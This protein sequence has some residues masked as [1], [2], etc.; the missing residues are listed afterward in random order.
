MSEELARR[1]QVVPLFKIDNVVT[2]AMVNP[3]D[4]F[5]IDTLVK[6][7]GFR[8]EPVACMRTTI[9]ETIN[10]L[11]GGLEAAQPMNFEVQT[12]AAVRPTIPRI[13]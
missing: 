10:K 3:L 7:L 13:T 4:V 11:Y 12:P 8:I 5:I 2:V 1:L 9:F 6:T